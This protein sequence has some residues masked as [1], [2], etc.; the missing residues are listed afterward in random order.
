M[1][2][3]I[4]L[5]PTPEPTESPNLSD[6]ESSP[7][8]TAAPEQDGITVSGGDSDTSSAVVMVAESIDYTSYLEELLVSEQY[9]EE[10][11]EL[12]LASE[13]RQESQLEGALSILLIIIVVG[14]LNYIYKFFKMFF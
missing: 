14:V 13:Q 2:D 12:I 11:L 6:A 3:T 8:E 5:T 10:Q 1:T 4:L 7:E 9:Q